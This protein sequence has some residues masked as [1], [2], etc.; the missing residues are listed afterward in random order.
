M[1][2]SIAQIR[3][4]RDQWERAAEDVI[5]GWIATEE[6]YSCRVGSGVCY[7]EKLKNRHLL[8]Y[9]G[10]NRQPTGW[11]CA[12]RRPPRVLAH[13]LWLYNP[14]FVYLMDD[15]TFVNIPRFF[16]PDS[17]LIKYIRGPLKTNPLVVGRLQFPYGGCHTLTK[18]GMILGGQGYL[19]GQAVLDR[20]QSYTIH[21]PPVVEDKLRSVDQMKYLSILR[22]AYEAL[23]ECPRVPHMPCL[24]LQ[25]GGVWQD[26]K[27][28]ASSAVRLVDLCVSLMSKEHTC[29]NSDHAISICLAHG[30]Y[31]DFTRMDYMPGRSQ[32]DREFAY[33]LGVPLNE[34]I[35]GLWSDDKF[36]TEVCDTNKRLTCHRHVYNRT[37]LTGIRSTSIL[38]DS[39]AH[40][41]AFEGCV[42]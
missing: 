14:E 23:H 5:A 7:P 41:H 12:Q 18:Q 17:P 9:I 6:Q 13:T 39:S 42:G 38:K 28:V 16:I 24:E 21:G 40:P 15:D 32:Q 3:M 1:D 30:A 31:A 35:I 29:Y 11:R 27:V 26:Y 20:L 37:D 4:L 34:D 8:T 36:R 2:M 10:M 25:G 33:A 19:M 22:S